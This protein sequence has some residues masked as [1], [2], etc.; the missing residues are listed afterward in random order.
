MVSTR[1]KIRQ[2]RRQLSQL[3]KTL[4]ESVHGNSTNVSAIENKTLVPQ[5]NGRFNNGECIFNGENSACQNQV[6]EDKID[7]KIRKVVYIAVMTLDNRMHDAV[8][9]AMDSV[10]I[11]QVEMVIRSFT[12][13]S[14]EGLS[15]VVQKPDRK[16]F[17]G[18]TEKNPLMSASG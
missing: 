8:F 10:V 15:S 14:G 9:T 11:P 16:D 5:A 18:N 13:S 7:D 6:L 4:N 17:T 12:G 2:Q 3:N 1:K